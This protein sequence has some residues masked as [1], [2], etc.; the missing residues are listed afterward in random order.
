MKGVID[1]I[2]ENKT[3]DR[4]KDYWV[5]SIGGENYSVWDK[6]YVEGLQEGAAVEYGWMQSG[7]FRKITEI[8]TIDMEPDERLE[9]RFNSRNHQIMR[10][11]CIKSATALLSNCEG[12]PDE[13]GEITVTLARKFEQYVR[14]GDDD[15][16]NDSKRSG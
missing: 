11:S 8:R 6:K 3:K 10:L 12:S 14:E 13:K 5:L 4:K 7:D 2:W 9:G 16:K 1:R 15:E